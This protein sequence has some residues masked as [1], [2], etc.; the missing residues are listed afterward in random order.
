MIN[1]AGDFNRGRNLMGKGNCYLVTSV[2]V[3]DLSGL[4]SG[5]Q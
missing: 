5:A 3:W 4:I 1:I 2:G